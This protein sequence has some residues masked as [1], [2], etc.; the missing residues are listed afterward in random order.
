MSTT[1]VYSEEELGYF[2]L[3]KGVINHATTALRK[4]FRKEWNNVHRHKSVWQDDYR[5]GTQL[6]AME[7]PCS[8]LLDPNFASDYQSIKDKLQRGDTEDWDVT[9]LVFAL[10]YSGAL[11]GIRNNRDPHWR[12]IKSAIYEIKDIRNKVLSHVAK[13]SVPPSDYKRIFFR[14]EDAVE[15]LLSRSDPL[16]E[17]LKTLRLETE[18]VTVDLIKYKKLLQD[19][20]KSLLRLEKDLESLEYKMNISSAPE[21]RET[22]RTL[23]SFDNGTI[24]K[25][26]R[27]RVDR[28]ERD[29]SSGPDDLTP[30]RFKPSIF[31]SAKYIRLM[32]KSNCLASNFRWE[33]LGNFLKGFNDGEDMEAFAGIQ[34]AAALSYRSRK[35]ESLKVLNDLIPKVIFCKQ[36]GVVLFARIKIFK[37]YYFHDCLDDESAMREADEAEMML[38]LGECHEDMAEIHCAKANI[39][40][41]SRKN[42]EDDRERILYHLDKCIHF[43]EKAPVDKSSASTQAKLRK[44]LFQLGYYQHGILEEAPKRSDVDTAKTILDRVAQQPDIPKRSEVYLKFGQSL[45]AYRQG[46]KDKATNIEKTLRQECKHLEITFEIEQLDMLKT[47]IHGRTGGVSDTVHGLKK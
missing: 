25:K 10:L 36:Y 9:T 29:L 27:R 43:C 1:N 19:D 21:K 45:L 6:L 4:L 7:Q 35:G 17:K 31:H 20:N 2:R 8:R 38:S 12:R 41:S 44:A 5:S 39:I 32:D 34:T 42:S 16:V 24:I 40:L 46:N 33:E 30:E 47:L 28:I 26:I 18:F 3:A 22:K 11:S 37:A 14:L 23:A 13:A 15:D